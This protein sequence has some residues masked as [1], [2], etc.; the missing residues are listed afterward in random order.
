[1]THVNALV[2]ELFALADEKSSLFWKAGGMLRE[3][4]LLP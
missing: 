3:V 4:S 1:M 2:D